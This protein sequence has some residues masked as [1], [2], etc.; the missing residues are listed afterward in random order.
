M[1]SFTPLIIIIMV[2]EYKLQVRYLFCI[3]H[4]TMCHVARHCL[5]VCA[6]VWYILRTIN[7]H[8][9]VDLRF[10]LQTFIRKGWTFRANN[11]HLLCDF[12]LLSFLSRVP[13]ALYRCRTPPFIVLYQ[14]PHVELYNMIT[15][16][17]CI[18]CVHGLSLFIC[19]PFCVVRKN[20]V[21]C[22]TAKELYNDCTNKDRHHFCFHHL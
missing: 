13:T 10:V 6:Y 5:Y 19:S 17:C 3:R 9:Y 15:V 18:V 4:Y 1:T 14:V 11:N 12:C 7:T 20:T 8:R 21:H 22:Q 2:Y 16:C